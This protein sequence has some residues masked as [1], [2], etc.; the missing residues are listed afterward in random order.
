MKFRILSPAC[1]EIVDIADYLR[2]QSGRGDEFLRLVFDNLDA[3]ESDPYSFP[4]WELNT[5]DLEIRRVLLAKFRYLIYYQITRDEVIVLTACHGSRDPG[6]WLSR[7]QQL[8]F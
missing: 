7:A 1:R 5:T 4:Q 3:I 2:T 8:G 6:Q